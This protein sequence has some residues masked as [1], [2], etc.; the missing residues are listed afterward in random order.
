MTS[1]LPAAI[2]EERLIDIEIKLARQ[3]DL[4]DSLSQ[5]I[6]QQ[7]KKITELELLL[8]GMARRLRQGGDSDNERAA[9]EHEKPPH[10]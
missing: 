1:P 2:S 7:Q 6:Y 3:E 10:Y 8:Q 5:T 4:L 9:I